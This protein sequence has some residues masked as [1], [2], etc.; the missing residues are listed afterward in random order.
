MGDFKS[1]DDWPYGLV[2]GRRAASEKTR[3]K[4][5]VKQHYGS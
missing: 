2:P 5:D 3:K 1:I 4:K